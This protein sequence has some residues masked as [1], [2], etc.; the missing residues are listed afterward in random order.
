MFHYNNN[1]YSIVLIYNY[2]KYAVSFPFI[3]IN[4]NNIAATKNTSG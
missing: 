2:F 4:D 1:T 3:I